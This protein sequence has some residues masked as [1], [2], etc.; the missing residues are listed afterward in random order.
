MK[1]SEEWAREIIKFLQD[2]PVNGLAGATAQI[3][4]IVNWV[5]LDALSSKPAESIRMQ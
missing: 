2:N 1:T 4:Q 5:Q 3:E